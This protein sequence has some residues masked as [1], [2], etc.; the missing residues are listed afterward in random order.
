MNTQKI[1]IVEDDLLSKETLI[2]ILNSYGYKNTHWVSNGMDAFNYIKDVKVDL[3]LMDIALEGKLDGI[4]TAKI[5]DSNIP[6]IFT[7]SS[8][9]SNTFKRIAGTHSYGFLQKP[10]TPALVK[11]AIDNAFS[12]KH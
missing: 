10:Y 12:A 9:D 5:V 1:L 6:V 8:K 4:D 3:I 7:S 2:Q 11:E